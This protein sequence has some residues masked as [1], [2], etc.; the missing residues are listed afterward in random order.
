MKDPIT[1]FIDLISVCNISMI[2]FKER[3]YGYYLHGRS[4]FTHADTDMIGLLANLK[5]EEVILSVYVVLTFQERL[6]GSRGL[7]PNS[8]IQTF[9]LIATSAL[10]EEYDKIY[11]LILFQVTY[12]CNI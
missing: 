12:L 8:D 6:T 5:Q 10:R 3:C 7:L 9:E 1:Q 11:L 4:V 2:L